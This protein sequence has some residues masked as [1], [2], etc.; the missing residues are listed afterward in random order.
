LEGKVF[1]FVNLSIPTIIVLTPF[2]LC[3]ELTNQQQVN[4][5]MNG[6]SST[7]FAPQKATSGAPTSALP[8][9]SQASSVASANKQ[10]GTSGASNSVLPPK[11]QAVIQ[12]GT[13]RGGPSPFLPPSSQ[14][15]VFMQN[16]TTFLSP[17]SQASVVSMQNATS[18]GVPTTSQASVVLKAMSGTPSSSTQISGKTKKAR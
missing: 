15:S 2:W 14:A 12:N 13:S 1:F 7:T 8:K 5:P 11:S 9:A 16:G 6:G 3:S 10:N 4:K 17:P 18:K